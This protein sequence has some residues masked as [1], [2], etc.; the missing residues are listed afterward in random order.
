MDSDS[1]DLR[2]I[3]LMSGTSMDGVDAAFVETDG[4]SRLIFGPSSFTPYGDEDRQVL[5][6]ALERAAS[7]RLLELDGPIALASQLITRRHAEA[8]ESFMSDHG[9]TARSVDAVGFHGQ[10]VLHLPEQG[11]SLQ[12]GDGQAL[13]DR[14]GISVVYDFRSADVQAGGQ[15]A[16]IAPVFHRAL[17]EASG[18]VKPIAFLNI[19]GVA[20]VTYIP[21][22]GDPIACDTGPGNALMDD[23]I[24]ART[25]VAFDCDGAIASRGRVDAGALARLL[26]HPYFSRPAPKSL[27]RNEFSSAPVASASLEDALATLAA[28]TAECVALTLR[29]I[30][31]APTCLVVGGGGARNGALLAEL[32]RRTGVPVQ[33]ADALGWS[34]DAIEAQA[35][36]YLAARS[37]RGLPLTFPKTTGAPRPLPGGSLARPK[38]G[39]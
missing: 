16:P 10:T 36:A 24:L 27:D 5:R 25:G 34:A 1:N 8:V 30:G 26:D 7:V 29:G 18:L 21:E 12:I 13:A 31:P 37:L 23:L 9:L 35:F 19:G 4:E 3:G 15:G 39:G 32:G 6:A 17:V 22:R 20:N 28:F 33:A 14:L 11:V 2:I 38:R